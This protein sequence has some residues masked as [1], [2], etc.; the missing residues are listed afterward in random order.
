MSFGTRI[1]RWRSLRRRI[2]RRRRL[3]RGTLVFY[4]IPGPDMIERGALGRAP[5]INDPLP[6]TGLIGEPVGDQIGRAFVFA[7]IQ[8]ALVFFGR[9]ESK[10]GK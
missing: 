4:L 10:L 5:L 2:R 1:G 6:K 9:E 3:R 8:N 7:A